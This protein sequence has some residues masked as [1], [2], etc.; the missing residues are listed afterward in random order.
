MRENQEKIPNSEVLAENAGLCRSLA[1]AVGLGVEGSSVAVELDFPEFIR[2]PVAEELLCQ[3]VQALVRGAV[4]S[5]ES[6]GEL[7]VTAWEA[8][9]S[10]EIEVADSGPA[11]E[12]RPRILPIAAAALNAKLV[13]QNCPQGGVAVTAMIP[14]VRAVRFAA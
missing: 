6:H 12:G 2:F 13:W 7:Y 4:A 8:S 10:L 3:L 14:R 11:L 5:F 1:A 9:D